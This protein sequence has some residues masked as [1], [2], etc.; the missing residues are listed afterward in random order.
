[1]FCSEMGEFEKS[2]LTCAVLVCHLPWTCLGGVGKKI[3]GEYVPTITQPPDNPLLFEIFHYI[4]HR[5]RTL[6]FTSRKTH[7]CLDNAFGVC[8][9]QIWRKTFSALFA[10]I[11]TKKAFL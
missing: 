2:V 9:K 4:M 5:P 8:D 3:L 11:R 7:C 10:E 6:N 1:M